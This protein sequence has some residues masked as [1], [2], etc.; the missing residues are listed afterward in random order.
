[1]KEREIR[2]VS[3]KECRSELK[4][5]NGKRYIVGRIPYDS[6]S[7]DLGGYRE[8]I[9]RGAFDKTINDGA[10][11]KALLNHD[12]SRILGRIKNGT[13]KLE[14]RGD[15]LY[16]SIELGN[17]TY[18]NDL[19]ESIRRDDVNT[20]SFGFQK[21]KDSWEHEPGKTSTRKLHEVKLLEVSYGVT[22]PAYSETN[23][24]AVYRSVYESI[25]VDFDIINQAIMKVNAKSELTDEEEKQIRSLTNYI[26]TV[27]K[28][29][30]RE[31][32]QESTQPEVKVIEPKPIEEPQIRTLE[33]LE[34]ELMLLE[35]GL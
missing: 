15:G 9:L 26:S 5:E 10:D 2:N 17:Q 28:P 1:M 24:Q 32:P 33:V 16:C 29:E 30:Q 31:E 35:K 21:I 14:S 23:S 18:A 8:I 13:L 20:L 25:G 34:K 11:V 4:E 6:V 7:G 27:L 3:I 12:D 19:W 22:F